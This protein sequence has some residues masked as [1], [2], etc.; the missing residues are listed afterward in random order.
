MIVYK[1]SKM[2]M[3][4]AND[5]YCLKYGSVLRCYD[6]IY[7]LTMV[8][9]HIASKTIRRHGLYF[10]QTKKGI[11]MGLFSLVPCDATFPRATISCNLVEPPLKKNTY[12]FGPPSPHSMLSEL[13]DVLLESP[14]EMSCYYVPTTLIQG[15]GGGGRSK[16]KNFIFFGGVQLI[17]N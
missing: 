2:Q 13:N 14:H 8:K 9:N 11:E 10:S 1:N 3:L 17:C 16:M 4:Q 7:V 15:G 5:G 12:V 6:V